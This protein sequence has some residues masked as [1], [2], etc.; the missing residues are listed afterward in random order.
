ML[1]VSGISEISQSSDT[2]GNVE[3]QNSI[4]P[5]MTVLFVSHKHRITHGRKEARVVGFALG[6]RDT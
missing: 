1:G 5:Y 4:R 2:M 3:Y 6:R